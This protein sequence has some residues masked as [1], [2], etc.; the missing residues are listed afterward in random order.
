MW[1]KVAVTQLRYFFNRI[2][3]KVIE[4]DELVFLK[5]FAVETVS[6]FEM[7]V[8]LAFFDVMVHLVVH[9]VSQ[10]EALGPMYLHEWT[11]ECFMSILNGYVSTRARPEASMVEGY[12]TEEVIESGGP[13]CNRFA[14]VMTRG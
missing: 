4:R 12:L 1:I 7:C 6:Q 13:F 2:S 5:E 8:P 3:Q 9:L 11:Y 14:S 10:I